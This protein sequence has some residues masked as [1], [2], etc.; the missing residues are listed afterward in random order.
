MMGRAPEAATDIYSAPEEAPADGAIRIFK[1]PDGGEDFIQNGI[2][3]FSSKAPAAQAVADK[4]NEVSKGVADWQE[5]LRL[6]EASLSPVS[7]ITVGG[8]EWFVCEPSFEMLDLLAA[9]E[10]MIELD[11]QGVP[12]NFTKW[13]SPACRAY[14]QLLLVKGMDDETPLFPDDAS[15]DRLL[16]MRGGLGIC[17]QLLIELSAKVKSFLAVV[18]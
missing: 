10:A 11:E 9:A 4:A 18:E 8:Q 3:I 5:K 14:F 15:V 17:T 13:A 12:V 1:R 7:A 2:T 16:A 6:L